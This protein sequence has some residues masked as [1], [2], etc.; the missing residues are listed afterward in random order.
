M[1]PRI[2]ICLAALL[3][4]LLAPRIRAQDTQHTAAIFVKNHADGVPDEKVASLEDLI[5][6]HLSDKGFR[7]ISRDD[8]L[9]AVSSFSSAGPNAG[10]PAL[11]GSQ[12]DALM[13]NNTSALRLA[14]NLNAD[15]ILVAS[16]S[17]YGMD[18]IDYN[19]PDSGVL[20]Q[21]R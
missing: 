16:I 6:G 2:L 11:A 1:K 7:I 14:Q 3:G 20:D 12:L 10:N 8:A 17:T 18:E 21:N 5:S 13:S 9:N 19:D 15:C 4:L